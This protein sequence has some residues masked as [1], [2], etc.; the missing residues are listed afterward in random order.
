MPTDFE[1]EEM[2]ENLTEAKEPGFV[3]YVLLG[4]LVAVISLVFLYLII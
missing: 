1:F 3:S 2:A 4:V